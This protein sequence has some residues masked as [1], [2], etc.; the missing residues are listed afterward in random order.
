MT[1]PT[2]HF[3]EY[4]SHHAGKFACGVSVFIWGDDTDP[5]GTT[6]G[7][8]PDDEKV[9]FA[10]DRRWELVNCEGCIDAA[11]K[12]LA[13]LAALNARIEA[14]G[15]IEAWNRAVDERLAAARARLAAKKLEKS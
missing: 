12:A 9:F 2:I 4:S 7:D 8:G 1:T 13:E 14:A 3:L 15:G 5:D 6:S 10:N 11:R